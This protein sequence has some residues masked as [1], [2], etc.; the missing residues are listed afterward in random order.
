VNRKQILAGLVVLAAIVVVV[1]AYFMFFAGSPEAALPGA[2]NKAG[3]TLTAADRTQGNLKAKVVV[4]EYAAPSCPHCAHWTETVYPEFKKKYIDTGKVLYVFRVFP[5][6]AADVAAE[7]MARCLPEDNY[8]HFIDLVFRNQPKWDPEYGVRDVHAG[9]VEMG[10]IAGM[11]ETQVDA[12]IANQ[13][14]QKRITE[15]G[16]DAQKK[17]S[18]NATPSFVINGTVHTGGVDWDSLQKVIDPLLKDEK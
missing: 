2:D 10:R 14:E 9:L 13:D 7:A 5:L 17:Y 11:S 8:F 6:N 16:T 12:C 1:A 18:I 15:V 3:V 4:V